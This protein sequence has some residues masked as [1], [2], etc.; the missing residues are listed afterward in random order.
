MVLTSQ[1]F[2]CHEEIDIESTY[3]ETYPFF[4]TIKKHQDDTI[5]VIH[6]S[7]MYDYVH[8]VVP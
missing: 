3:D 2:L 7:C 1:C 5:E 4:R 6:H 8:I